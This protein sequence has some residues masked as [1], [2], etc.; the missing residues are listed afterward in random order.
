MLLW[1]KPSPQYI[2]FTSL[3][4][5]FPGIFLVDLGV[6]QV[7][8][9]LLLYSHDL[10][11]L[12]LW[13]S[14]L[15]A[16]KLAISIAKC[17]FSSCYVL[18]C[19]IVIVKCCCHSYELHLDLARIKLANLFFFL[20]SPSLMSLFHHSCAL[21][22]SSISQARNLPLYH[23]SQT[24]VAVKRIEVRRFRVNSK[25]LPKGNKDRFIDIRS[26]VAI[27]LRITVA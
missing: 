24:T 3:C 9:P 6:C 16:L 17:T 19:P 2:L 13:T 12:L 25:C 8:L 21:S 1:L 22:H 27:L 5:R 10:S 4:S 7:L 18:Q 14:H 11:H 15:I 20:F 26:V 23:S